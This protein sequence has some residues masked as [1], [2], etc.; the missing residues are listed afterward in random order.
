M[1]PS[2]YREAIPL[3]TEPSRKIAF[4]IIG[5]STLALQVAFADINIAKDSVYTQSSYEK[6]EQYG[7]GPQSRMG[8]NNAGELPWPKAFRAKIAAAN[9]PVEHLDE[10]KVGRKVMK[11]CLKL[12][13]RNLSAVHL[14]LCSWIVPSLTCFVAAIALSA[15]HAVVHGAHDCRG[16]VLKKSWIY[17]EITSN[18][19]ITVRPCVG[20]STSEVGHSLTAGG[21][22]QLF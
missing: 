4:S 9:A 2:V 6:L 3:G 13:R 12:T 1:I 5:F 11:I 7:T 19:A 18:R 16:S 17:F 22:I 10:G 20:R 8:V 15:P 14:S 21:S